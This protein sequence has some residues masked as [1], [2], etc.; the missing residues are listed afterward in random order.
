MGELQVKWNEFLIALRKEAGKSGRKGAVKTPKNENCCR[1][2]CAV[3]KMDP[4][5]I[6]SILQ[7]V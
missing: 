4:M 6:P 3:T 5:F 2:Y 7:R 1:K